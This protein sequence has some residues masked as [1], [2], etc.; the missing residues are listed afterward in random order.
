MFTKSSEILSR[1]YRNWGIGI[2]ALPV[3]IGIALAGL[4]L[5]RPDPSSLMSDAVRTELAGAKTSP[6]KTSPAK[7]SPAAAPAQ[8]AQPATAAI[9]TVRTN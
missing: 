4:V 1:I 5:S 9:R 7:T 2:F 8:M 6:A 3:L